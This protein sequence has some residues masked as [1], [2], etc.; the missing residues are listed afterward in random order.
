MHICVIVN[1]LCL[2]EVVDHYSSLSL[3]LSHTHTH[4]HTHTTHTH[5]HTHTHTQTDIVRLSNYILSSRYTANVGDAFSIVMAASQLANNKVSFRMSL[6]CMHYVHT[7]YVHN[8]YYTYIHMVFDLLYHS[9][10][11][12]VYLCH[13]CYGVYFIMCVPSYVYLHTCD[14]ESVHTYM[15]KHVFLHFCCLQ[16]YVPTAV[17]AEVQRSVTKGNPTFM[18]RMCV[19]LCGSC[20]KF[21]QT[22]NTRVCVCVRYVCMF[23]SAGKQYV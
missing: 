16:F 3:S 4:T 14:Y 7:W 23:V 5:A 20:A 1:R 19:S 9:R 21:A 6:H 22:S 2:A 15:H 13:V 17:N 8:A 18:V 10:K 12:L 11:F